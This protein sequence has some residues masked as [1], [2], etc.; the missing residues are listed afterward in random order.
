[1]KDNRVKQRWFAGVF[2]S[3]L[4]LYLG[5]RAYHHWSEAREAENTAVKVVRAAIRGDYV[6]LRKYQFGDELDRVGISLADYKKYWAAMLDGYISPDAKIEVRPTPLVLPKARN[7][8]EERIQ[9]RIRRRRRT[10]PELNVTVERMDGKPPITF[11]ANAWRHEDGWIV[12]ATSTLASFQVYYSS[13]PKERYGRV[14]KVMDALS[15]KAICNPSG[16][17]MPVDR[18]KMFLR[19]EITEKDISTY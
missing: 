18:V 12:S 2:V 11:V 1:M 7:E 3:M 5:Y 10:S 6:T 13:D 14:A 15:L 16:S 8:F 9:D 19:D 4:S 17:W